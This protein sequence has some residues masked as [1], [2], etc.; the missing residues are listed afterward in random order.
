MKCLNYYVCRSNA[1]RGH[2]LCQRC[3]NEATRMD[4]QLFLPRDDI[5]F[6]RD[7]RQKAE[8]EH[9]HAEVKP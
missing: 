5:R 8:N 6:T 3:I 4:E 1:K 7:E 2:S 9:K